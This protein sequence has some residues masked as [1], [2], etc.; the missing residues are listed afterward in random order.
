[1]VDQ[2]ADDD[3]QHL[4]DMD[5]IL[6]RTCSWEVHN[7]QSVPGPTTPDAHAALRPEFSQSFAPA[8]SPQSRQ[9]DTPVALSGNQL[10]SWGSSP[11]GR[12]PSSS[13]HSQ[14]GSEALTDRNPFGSGE[15]DPA[16]TCSA[17]LDPELFDQLCRFQGMD[18]AT[19]VPMAKRRRSESEDRPLM[20]QSQLV[21][22]ST[23]HPDKLSRA[24]DSGDFSTVAHFSERPQQ[25]RPAVSLD[26]S[27]QVWQTD[28]SAAEQLLPQPRT[29]GLPTFTAGQAQSSD[30]ATRLRGRRSS[31]SLQAL[32]QDHWCETAAPLHPGDLTNVPS[33]L[34]HRRTR[35]LADGTPP[36]PPSRNASHSC[37]QGGSP[38]HGASPG[39]Q[40]HQQQQQL[41]QQQQQQQWGTQA[42]VLELPQSQ[43]AAVERLV[44]LDFKRTVAGLR[45]DIRDKLKE[46]LYRISRS[47]NNRG[48]LMKATTGPGTRVG[49]RQAN[50]DGFVVQLLYNS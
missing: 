34:Q 31:P 43:A 19:P 15:I 38:S 16:L 26:S 7:Q 49:G 9:L 36:R 11:L 48:G 46:S 25:L 18:L 42:Q 47:T 35:S 21:S 23:W 32:Q 5:D 41:Q 6:T 44:V 17:D 40:Q 4:L 22:A 29:L 13:E 30:R 14:P 28:A 2:I 27:L 1:M 45:P 39:V 3:L 33:P 20:G 37:L 8:A 12:R 24:L 10:H 50:M